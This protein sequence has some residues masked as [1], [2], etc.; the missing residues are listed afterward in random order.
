MPKLVSSIMIKSS[1]INLILQY[2]SKN[3]KLTLHESAKGE[4][5]E[6]I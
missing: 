4:Q 3:E 1:T 5:F 6:R 2:Q